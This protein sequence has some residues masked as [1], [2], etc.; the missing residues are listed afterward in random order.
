M[1]GERLEQGT[2]ERD[3]RPDQIG[4]H[5]DHELEAYEAGWHSRHLEALKAI[6]EG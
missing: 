5:A 2:E 1:T 3:G 4:E 6:V